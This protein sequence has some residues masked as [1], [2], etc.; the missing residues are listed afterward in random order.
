MS[1]ILRPISDSKTCPTWNSNHGELIKRVLQNQ[2]MVK[3]DG[4]YTED[5]QK[6]AD[7]TNSLLN[8]CINPN[9]SFKGNNIGLAL[10]YVQSGKTLSFTTLIADA[11]DNGFKMIILFSGIKNTLNSQTFGRLNDDLNLSKR[12]KKTITLLEDFG[13]QSDDKNKFEKYFAEWKDDDPRNHRKLIVVT[14]KH[15]E[16]LARLTEVVKNFDLERI[17]V[18]FIDDEADQAS[19]NTLEAKNAKT[20]LNEE[21]TTFERIQSLRSHIPFHSYIQYTATPQTLLLIND[22]NQL[23]PNFLNLITPGK[24]YTGG[25][26]YFLDKKKELLHTIFD[27]EKDTDE[28]KKIPKS[29]KKAMRQFF[30]ATA[31][32]DHPDDPL[33]EDNLTLMVH[34]AREVDE[35]SGMK[36]LINNE[37]RNWIDVLEL[38]EGSRAR[39]KLIQS[40]EE[41]FIE[42]TG[43]YKTDINFDEK[44]YNSILYTLKKTLIKVLNSE[45]QNQ[46]ST[47][48]IKDSFDNDSY[49]ILIGGDILDRGLTVEGLVTTYL[50]R[51]NSK[52]DDT[53]L[54]RARFFGYK[55]R[56]IDLCRV[57]MDRDSINVYTNIVKDEKRQR[58]FL[59]EWDT[60]NRRLN[61][62]DMKVFVAKYRKA[63]RETVFRNKLKK[64]TFGKKWN[65]IHFPSSVEDDNNL[66][67]VGDFYRANFHNFEDEL[68]EIKNSEIQSHT[69][70]LAP[71][72]TLIELLEN[73]KFSDYND[74]DTINY[75]I[76]YL[77]DKK[78][79][80]ES[81]NIGLDTTRVRVISMSSRKELDD[82]EQ[83]ERERTATKGK[84]GRGNY[85][86]G[87]NK[88]TGYIGDSLIRDDNC[89]TIQIS[90]FRLTDK[91]FKD[92]NKLCIGIAYW[93]PDEVV[94]VISHQK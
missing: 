40:F 14:K 31:F 58:E 79:P 63:S 68:Y 25:Y 81:I 91:V 34:P 73:I 39:K 21:S 83:F 45:K 69:S 88:G 6:I 51:A 43:T 16:S 89:P 38:E 64:N 36:K 90:K 4:T 11:I 78:V 59:E 12:E 72:K 85:L 26:T 94:N 2:K 75:L 93:I 28:N 8:R 49:H 71:R 41:E 18:L 23:S 5:G 17:P 42:I 32:N 19:L 53:S 9:G 10:G 82:I 66:D 92:Y 13:N 67:L 84:L 29:L 62:K 48:K 74:T 86:Q 60:Q 44:F 27:L 65:L 70:F 15:H 22:R 61:S 35:H 54:Q 80:N 57:W 3:E 50:S 87:E 20:K 76:A 52:Q 77:E 24:A 56:Y 7:T 33:D 30:I 55:K 47:R 1:G 46:E 37:I